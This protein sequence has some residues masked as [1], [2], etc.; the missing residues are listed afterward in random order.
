MNFRIGYK[1]MT[2]PDNFAKKLNNISMDRIVDKELKHKSKQL[3]F[4][5]WKSQGC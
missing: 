3:N 5:G 2:L 4:S 1:L